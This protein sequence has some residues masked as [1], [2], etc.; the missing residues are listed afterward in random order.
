MGDLGVQ[1]GDAVGEA[2]SLTQ[3]AASNLDVCGECCGRLRTKEEK[4]AQM[5]ATVK[6]IDGVNSSDSK[7]LLQFDGH[8]QMWPFLS[9]YLLWL[10]VQKMS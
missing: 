1:Q 5:L 7:Q 2:L 9:R 8:G 10:P 6:D 3:V 4:L